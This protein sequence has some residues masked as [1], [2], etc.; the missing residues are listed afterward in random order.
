MVT[1]TKDYRLWIQSHKLLWGLILIVTFSLMRVVETVTWR[2]WFGSSDFQESIPFAL[3]LLLWFV[4]MSGGLI[5]CGIVR[6]TKTSWRA[7]GWKQDGIAKSIG[8]GLVG[9]ALMYINV[10]V[11]SMLKGDTDPPSIVSPSPA[12]LLLVM[13]F[14]FGLPAWVEENLY[15]GY[16]QPL[17]AER[18]GLR[19]AIMIQAALFSVAHL[20]YLW[21]LLD[22]GSAFVTGL[23]LGW[24]RGRDGNLAAPFL[25]H[26]LFWM[27]GAF[28]VITP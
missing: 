18:M 5:A 9:F 20:G 7:L 1:K 19:I 11:W 23:I 3:F 28:M 27:M 25:A 17:L 6:L 10:V 12:R 13:F 24:L 26:G 15:R 16:L 4:L 14:A 22:F 2:Q 8:M 21:H